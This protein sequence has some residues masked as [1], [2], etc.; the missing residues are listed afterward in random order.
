V[1]GAQATDAV[2][3]L[4]LQERR[5]CA[6]CG[7]A[8]LDPLLEIAA[9]PVHM[10][11][12]D[13][14]P[15]DDVFCDQRW[16]TCARCGSVQLS[17][18][19]P[20]D[21][22]YQS[23]HNAAVGG[24]WARHHTAL[25]D[26]VAVRAPRTVVEVGGSSGALARE[27]AAAHDVASWTVVEPNPTFTPQPP[28]HLITAYVEEAGEV[29]A[30]ADAVVHSHLLEHLYEPRAFLRGLREQLRADARMLLS[31]PNLP[32][33]L[34]QSGANA[35]NFEHTYFFDEALLSWMLR[36]AGF[37]V[38]EPARFEQH[39]LFLAA[40]PDAEPGAAGPPPDATGGARAF[41]RFV[42]AA[43]ADAEALAARAEAFDG[44]V[45]LFGAHVFSQFLIGC[46]FPSDRAVAV[47][48]NDPHKQG[49]RLY[50][51]PL[52]V[53]ALAVLAE[54]N[55]PTP[56]AAVIVRAT[57]YTAEITEQLRTLAPQVEIW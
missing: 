32:A 46:G 8:R 19:A 1:T 41:A 20:L 44:P 25:A 43:R 53:A 49:R 2:A 37:T 24:V 54:V 22:V 28:I 12:T 50:G 11:C 52:A 36:D 18:L 30:E 26:F 48:D 35:L 14:P 9:V 16:A 57:H 15:A 42:A 33:L 21:L 7:A 39:S 5:A 45:Y 34:D 51:T 17:A 55:P 56:S 23:Q 31:V 40:R 4:A 13:R 29:V 27:Y 3:S 10:G 38:E 6:A 47:L